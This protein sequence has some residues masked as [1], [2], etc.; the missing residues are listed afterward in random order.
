MPEAERRDKWRDR[1]THGAPLAVLLAAG[2]FVG[3]QWFTILLPILQ[4]IVLAM[5]LALVL[6]TVVNGLERLGAPPWLAVLIVILGV[7]ALGALIVFVIVPNVT[8]E[9]QILINSRSS[10]LES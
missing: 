3:Y 6:R 8:R 9:V 10:Y 1:L 7:G 4:L 5:L 2:L